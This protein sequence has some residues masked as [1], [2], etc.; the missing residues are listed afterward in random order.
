MFVKTRVWNK[1]RKRHKNWQMQQDT[2]VERPL[3][4]DKLFF[5]STWKTWKEI[6]KYPGPQVL[7]FL[8]TLQ[9]L[10]KLLTVYFVRYDFFNTLVESGNLSPTPCTLHQTS[11]HLD[12]RRQSSPALALV[13]DN[14]PP[15]GASGLFTAF[16]EFSHRSRSVIPLSSFSPG[17]WFLPINP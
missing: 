6:H 11:S 3:F 5:D 13:T 7:Q 14:P 1:H 10:Y 17:V 2:W 16:E 12:I 8:S 4:G 15:I 9:E